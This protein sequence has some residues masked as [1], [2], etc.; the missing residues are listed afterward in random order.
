MKMESAERVDKKGR[1]KYFIKSHEVR[2]Q[3][4][5]TDLCKIWTHDDVSVKKS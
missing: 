1:Y 5:T 4:E 2:G 3:Q